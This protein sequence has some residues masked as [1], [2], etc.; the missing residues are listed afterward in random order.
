MN[1][2][3]DDG[4]LESGAPYEFR[5]ALLSVLIEVKAGQLMMK[6]S[7]KVTLVPLDQLKAMYAPLKRGDH[8]RE[9]VLA[10]E[11]GGRLKRARV[12]AN[13]H[14]PA[15]ERLVSA[16]KERLP[17]GDL[18]HLPPAEAYA[19]LGSVERPWVAVPALMLAT[20]A[21][22]ALLS[23]PLLLHGLDG[24]PT[25][26]S[27]DALERGEVTL[28]ELQSA[29]LKVEGVA[30]TSQL[31]Q[32]SDRPE[33]LELLAPLYG[34]RAYQAYQQQKSAL[35]PSRLIV[36]WSSRGELNLEALTTQRRF[37]GLLRVI[38][39]EGL[40]VKERAALSTAGVSLAASPVL[41]ELHITPRDELTLFLSLMGLLMLLTWGVW[42]ALKPAVSR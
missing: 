20:T 19:A 33:R 41:L 7:T 34:E 8:H 9:L 36:K 28:E 6:T 14:E 10:Y 4:A 27:L 23:A 30:D 21:L 25:P 38:A 22:V 40:S 13:L 24:P 26:L 37:Q 2:T 29:H 12:F 42:R 5:Y 15:F 18:S 11:R 16:L 17:E 1:N 32:V 3:R 35:P 39:W 31:A